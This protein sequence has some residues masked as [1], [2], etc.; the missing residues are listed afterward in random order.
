MI[1]FI[2]ENRHAWSNWAKTLCTFICD[3]FYFCVIP[4]MF[5]FQ[6]VQQISGQSSQDQKLLLQIKMIFNYNIIN[7]KIK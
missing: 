5:M 1:F 2:H 4:L 7:N 3:L 6:L